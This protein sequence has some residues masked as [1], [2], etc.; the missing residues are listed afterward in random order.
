MSL[1][2]SLE[3][4][5]RKYGE[6][7]H[8]VDGW[9]A[10]SAAAAGDAVVCGKGCS[11]CCRGVFDITLLD[12]YYLRQGFD[13]LS[14]PVKEV[15]LSRVRVQLDL[16]RSVWPD[17]S[18]PYII[19][20]LAEEQCERLMPEDDLTPCCLLDENGDCLVYENRPMTC[21]LHGLP[22]VDVSGEIFQDE[23]CTRNF[24]AEDP[25]EK[26]SLRWDFRECFQRELMLFQE[27]MGILLKQKINELDTC[28]PMAL[29]IDFDTFDWQGWWRENSRQIRS[30]GFPESR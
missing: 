17:M 25:L 15:V 2:S 18:H 27:F 13:K 4:L 30:V 19:N 8:S 23:W 1:N 22:L 9:F 3:Q 5:L 10:R 7:L 24:N 14:S 6:L 16:L 12:A 28:V 11:A 21:R 26:E 29:L 20:V